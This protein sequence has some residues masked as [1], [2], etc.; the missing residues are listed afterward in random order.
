VQGYKYASRESVA[1]LA[2][3]ANSTLVNVASSMALAKSKKAAICEH[4]QLFFRLEMCVDYKFSNHVKASDK[5]LRAVGIQSQPSSQPLV[6]TH[7]SLPCFR[8]N[9]QQIVLA[10]HR[11][12]KGVI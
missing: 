7:G 2:N 11:G 9:S 1:L 10:I 3:P 12:G 8:V 5:G 4:L 6:N